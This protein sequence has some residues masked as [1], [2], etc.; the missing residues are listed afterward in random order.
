[1]ERNNGGQ[2]TDQYHEH[3]VAEFETPVQNTL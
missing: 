3:L 1:M 2:R